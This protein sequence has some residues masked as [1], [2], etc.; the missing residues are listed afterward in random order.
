MRSCSSEH[1]PHTVRS[2]APVSTKLLQA[3]R[4]HGRIDGVRRRHFVVGEYFIE[5]RARFQ[6]R[7]TIGFARQFRQIGRPGF[8]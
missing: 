3:D 8:R 4:L 5:M 1:F 6:I 7:L 2:H